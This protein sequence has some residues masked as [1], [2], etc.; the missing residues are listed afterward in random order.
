VAVV[1][2]TALWWPRDSAGPPRR[3]QFSVPTDAVL[4]TTFGVD[5]PV[6][7]PD[8]RLLAFVSPAVEGG[9][10]AVWI[11]PLD[12]ADARMVA[13]T[14][15]ARALFWSPDSRSIGYGAGDMI[16]RVGVGV[17]AGAPQTL[18]ELPD[19]VGAAWTR[20]G[21]ILLNTASAGSGFALFRVS[22]QGGPPVELTLAGAEGPAKAYLWPAL[23]PDDRHFIYLGWTLNDDGR[24]LY[25]GS[26]DGG[27]PVRLMQADA[28][29][30]YVEPGFLL[31]V[32]AGTVFAQRFDSTALTLTGEPVRLADDVA[33]NRLMGRAAFSA[34]DNGTLVY[35]TSGGAGGLLELVWVDR[36]GTITSAVGDAARFYQIR[37]SP[38]DRRVA[39]SIGDPGSSVL[40]VLELGN[41]VFSSVTDSQTVVN[42]Q[43]W[44][45]DS[46]TVAYEVAGGG[47]TKF[48]K[49]VVGSQTEERLFESPGAP[50]YLDDWSPDGRFML[51]HATEPGQL[52]V[53]PV[54]G[55]SEP[56][57]L[58][59]SAEGIDQAHFSP[60]GAW[61]AY[62]ITESNLPQVWVASFPAFDQRRRVSP[63]GGGQPVWAR[64][65]R[66]L[67]YLTPT[68]ALMAVPVERGAAGAID[69]KAP[70]ELFQSPLTGPALMI[71]QYAVSK[72]GQR[73]LFIR[74]RASAGAKPPITVV[75][76]WATS[77]GSK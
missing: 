2:V 13:G 16:Y 11:R 9:A 26:L 36:R 3:I 66:E 68:G 75:V 14:S 65:G 70:V 40:S 44:S 12:A 55:S 67:F 62:Q 74:P 1:A 6:V 21:S 23:L 51:F 42:D 17:D 57:L 46:Q 73:F 34:S 48:L 39:A 71:D 8:G 7:S 58:L 59:D 25:V 47:V 69:V 33:T 49:R 32:R 43:A 10:P 30:A 29:A 50:R 53:L 52:F 54:D 19:F 64:D 15:G 72:D 61:I 28:M 41:G 56:R 60:D 37:L 5:R 22:E 27:T 63:A 18:C 35:R 45:P 20:S 76:N 77:L 38:D 4:A 24:Q 31:F